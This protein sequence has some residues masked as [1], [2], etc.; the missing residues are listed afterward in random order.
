MSYL[1]FISLFISSIIIFGGCKS[2]NEKI[3]VL[4]RKESFESDEGFSVFVDKFYRDIEI[5][6]IKKRRPRKVI[7]KFSNLQY[8]ETEH[9]THGISFGKNDDSKIEIYI[10]PITW[11]KSS[12]SKKY[13]L[14]YHELSH[15]ILNLSDLEPIDENIG[16]LMYP[17]FTTQYTNYSMDD[18]INTFHEEFQRIG[19]TLNNNNISKT[20]EQ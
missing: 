9:H 2:E 17:Y 12:R 19:K 3:K 6:G 16:K 8:L 7:I 18:F 14:M 13:L 11:K 20:L 15:D 1:K 5:Y 4:I 10:N